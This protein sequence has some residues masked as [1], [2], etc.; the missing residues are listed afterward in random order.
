MYHTYTLI[1]FAVN[2]KAVLIIKKCACSKVGKSIYRI[3]FNLEAL[4]EWTAILPTI[5]YS[6]IILWKK[7]LL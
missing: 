2:R 1:N 4:Q 6:T 5:E 7:G 3:G